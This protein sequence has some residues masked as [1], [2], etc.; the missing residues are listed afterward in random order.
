MELEFRN[1]D[2]K[3]IFSAIGNFATV[4]SN[5]LLTHPNI[6]L[7][8]KT[9]NNKTFKCYCNDSNETISG[10]NDFMKFIIKPGYYIK[11]M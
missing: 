11:I 1:E 2:G 4:M 7:R 5:Y 9:F 6:T 10:S 8:M 3:F